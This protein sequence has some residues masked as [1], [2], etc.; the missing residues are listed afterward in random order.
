[1]APRKAWLAKN[2]RALVIKGTAAFL[3]L[4]F[5]TVLLHGNWPVAL[6]CVSSG[7][8]LWGL[9]D[10]L[11]WRRERTEILSDVDAMT[12]EAFRRYAADLLH[13]QGYTVQRV[14]RSAEPRVDLLLTRGRETIVCWVQ[15]QVKR[16]GEETVAAAVAAMEARG[17]WRVMIVAN[18]LFT[19]RAR[20]RARREGCVLIGRESLAN[21]V[22]QHRRGHRVLIFQREEA[23]GL[24]R[25][26]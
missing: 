2:V 15:H 19:R 4:V 11:R 10:I 20:R 1:M 22:I 6:L 9:F 26:K 3:L 24:R 7:I 17:N 14:G 5:V 18:Q 21:L 8:G 25:R 16:V 13:T 12:G 23:A